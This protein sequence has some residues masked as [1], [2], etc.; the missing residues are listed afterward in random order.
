VAYLTALGADVWPLLESLTERP[1]QLLGVGLNVHLEV[2]AGCLGFEIGRDPEG[3]VSRGFLQLIDTD[4]SRNAELERLVLEVSRRE[5]PGAPA[6]TDLP[7]LWAAV[8]GYSRVTAADVQALEEHDIVILDDIRPAS[9]LLNC[10]LC[11]GPSRLP[12]GRV[13]WRH[14]GPLQMVQYD[15]IGESKVSAQTE[16]G[17]DPEVRFEEIP[18][19]LRFELAQWTASLGEIGALAP[20]AVL[21]LGQR[22]DDHAVSIWVEQRCIGKGQ[23]VAIG[24]RL[25]VR[26]L[27]VFSREHV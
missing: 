24:E 19:N 27:S 8:V 23:L 25:G 11:V 21:D 22:V 4:S 2:N 13:Q 7:V 6:R 5:M 9:N 16:T 1:V 14:G 12:A 18:V 17:A 15:G 10:R 20:G 26:L 3:A